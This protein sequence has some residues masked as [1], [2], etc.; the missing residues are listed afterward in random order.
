MSVL[1]LLLDGGVR[2]T[3]VLLLALAIAG[4]RSVAPARRHLALAIGLAAFIVVPAIRLLA[5]AWHFAVPDAAVDWMARPVLPG[6]AAG[7]G[8]ASAAAAFAARAAVAIWFIGAL[9]LL[10]RLALGLVLSSRLLRSARPAAPTDAPSVGSFRLLWSDAI[11]VPV[12]IGLVSPAVVLPGAARSWTPAERSA[13]IT[14]E[15][16]HVRRCDGWTLLTGMLVRALYWPHPLVWLAVRRLR[17]ASEEACDQAVVR[18]GADA[19]DYAELLVRLAAGRTMVSS[20][21]PLVQRRGL[22]ARVEALLTQPPA[23]PHRS[24]SAVLA[25][26]LV[27]ALVL[28]AGASSVTAGRYARAYAIDEDLAARI[29]AAARAERLDP[30]LGFGLV[31]VESGFD[32]ERTSPGGAVGFTQLLPGTAATLAPGVTA[33]ELRDPDLNL[34]LGFRLLRR[35]LDGFPGRPEQAVLSYHHGPTAVREAGLETSPYL[36]RF[37]QAA[38]RAQTP[39]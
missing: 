37:R 10:G 35:L 21:T 4:A 9:L 25:T 5:P 30:P 14:H 28:T 3:P 12:A 17:Q 18:S 32:P 26:L 34:R 31:S 16:A 24:R 13:A 27:G 29:L 38:A 23:G 1:A 36:I 15:A 11:R 2:A 22:P 20:L 19:L 6:S 33:S 39:R 7:A 8:P